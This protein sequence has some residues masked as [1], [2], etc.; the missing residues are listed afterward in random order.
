MCG[1]FFG[2]RERNGYA[3]CFGGSQGLNGSFCNCH[4][5]GQWSCHV[6]YH[7]CWYHF[8]YSVFSKST[9]LVRRKFALLERACRDIKRVV[10]GILS[11]DSGRCCFVD[12][13]EFVA[14]KDS[15]APFLGTATSRK[16]QRAVHESKCRRCGCCYPRLSKAKD[17]QQQRFP[18]AKIPKSRVGQLV[19]RFRSLVASTSIMYFFSLYQ[20]FRRKNGGEWWG[21]RGYSDDCK[22]ELC[23][24][25]SKVRSRRGA[26]MFCIP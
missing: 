22:L 16:H 12:S 7:S 19:R 10:I 18:V 25:I 1:I 15:C 17:C 21:G 2:A 11:F 23:T 14:V 8:S 5:P 24:L 26:F 4:S 9:G 13:I 3:C 6:A 20:K